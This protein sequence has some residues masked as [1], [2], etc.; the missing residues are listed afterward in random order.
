MKK[1]LKQI[2]LRMWPYLFFIVVITVMI[3]PQLK[4]RATLIGNDTFFHFSRFYDTAMQIS[5][6]KFNWFQTNFG[7]QHSGR[8]VNAV[9][10]P[11][12]A[13]LNGLLLSFCKNWFVFQIISDYLICLL[14]AS[15]MLPLMR[16][17]R[18]SKFLSVGL[19]VIYINIGYIP[20]FITQMTFSGWGQACMPF[21]LLCGVKMLKKDKWITSDWLKLGLVIAALFQ[22]HIVSALLAV[23][24]LIPFFIVG[25]IK[26]SNKTVF[27]LDIVKSIAVFI[28]LS[29]NSLY[30]FYQVFSKNKVILPQKFDLAVNSLHLNLYHF[31]YANILGSVENAI[32]PIFTILTVLQLIYVFSN[33]RADLLNDVAIIWG[34]CLLLIS[35]PIF[36]WQVVQKI[37]PALESSFQF[38]SRLVIIAYPLIILGFGLTLNTFIKKNNRVKQVAKM[39]M[40]LLALETMVP[41]VFTSYRFRSN[42]LFSEEVQLQAKKS[43]KS[44][45]VNNQSFSVPVDYLPAKT[46]NI[47]I[48]KQKYKKDVIQH[49]KNFRRRIL[50]NGEQLI[51]WNG[52]TNGKIILPVI[53]Y[54]QSNLQVNGQQFKGVVN[55]IGN[56]EISQKEGKNTAV[57]SFSR[58]SGFALLIVL[59]LI[60]WVIAIIGLWFLKRN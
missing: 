24:L 32:L 33:L 49:F 12:F 17:L 18:I 42:H 35:S 45:L 8:V 36:P 10:G 59:N 38:P 51:S 39:A 60:C 22:I 53:L 31:S 55:S 57:L 46:S 37:F 20:S 26:R 4:S 34:F 58:L 16:S 19:S 5:T 13:Y 44:I 3:L 50:S 14:G 27:I 29:F 52:K 54:E 30:S 47:E 43:D 11:Y 25:I 7:F 48:A 9:Y 23:L 21:A 6:S 56:P 28:V 1:D 40:L 41:T 15:S 2:W